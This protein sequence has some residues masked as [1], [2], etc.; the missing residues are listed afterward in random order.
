MQLLQ[1]LNPASRSPNSFIER[2]DELEDKKMELLMQGAF[3]LPH[4]QE[5][6][7]MIDRKLE[8]YYRWYAQALIAGK[9]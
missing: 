4:L 1:L 7:L 3:F 8:K 6:F 9:I 5:Q 2:I